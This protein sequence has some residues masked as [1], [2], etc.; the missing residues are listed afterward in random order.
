M[1]PPDRHVIKLD[2]PVKKQ[3]TRMLKAQCPRCDYTVRVSRKHLSEKGAP[4][5]PIH[6]VSFEYEDEGLE[7]QEK[8]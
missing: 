1:G 2:S 3:S 6:K 5:C 8:E 7:E 4:I